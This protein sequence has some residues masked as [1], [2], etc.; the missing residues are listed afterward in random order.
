MFDI[1]FLSTRI[2][3]AVIGV[4]WATDWAVVGGD[5]LADRTTH[6]PKSLSTELDVDA[7]NGSRSHAK[8][9]ARVH[10]VRGGA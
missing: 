8:K 5:T 6:S 3:L 4:T 2:C 10:V 9:C 7:E 1:A